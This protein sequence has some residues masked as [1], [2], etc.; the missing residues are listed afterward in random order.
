MESACT[1]GSPTRLP[2]EWDEQGEGVRYRWVSKAS[3]QVSVFVNKCCFSLNI[4]AEKR[5]LK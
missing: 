1:S 2:P 5:V 4:L 3:K